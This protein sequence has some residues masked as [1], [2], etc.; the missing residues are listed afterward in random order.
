MSTEN[1]NRDL[2]SDLELARLVRDL[3]REKQPQRDLWVG[4]QRGI[5]DHPQATRDRQ[6]DY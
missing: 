6:S 2:I 4:I 5:L 1:N 3:D